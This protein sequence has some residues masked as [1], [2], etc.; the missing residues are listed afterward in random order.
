VYNHFA[1]ANAETADAP[2]GSVIPA[3]PLRDV[4]V[5]VIGI[6]G[7]FHECLVDWVSMVPADPTNA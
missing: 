2:P 3:P 1:M 6:G 7:I 4:K 5:A